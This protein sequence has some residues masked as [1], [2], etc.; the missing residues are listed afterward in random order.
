MAF[1]FVVALVLGQSASI[2]A[3]A[4]MD[5]GQAPVASPMN[6]AGMSMPAS[7]QGMK[8][9]CAHSEKNKTM[10]DAMCAACCATAMQ[11]AVAPPQFLV[12]VQQAVAFVYVLT[13]STAV[14]ELLPPEPPPPKA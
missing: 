11:S 14:G 7:Y 8:N 1:L 5:T 6:M 4:A 3:M 13:E 12:P 9:C 10:K 2:A